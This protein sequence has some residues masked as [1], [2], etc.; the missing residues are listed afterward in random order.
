[1]FEDLDALG[2]GRS[3][4]LE[5]LGKVTLIDVVGAHAD[6]QAMSAHIAVTWDVP[7]ASYGSV[8]LGGPPLD[9][10]F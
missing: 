10:L 7:S 9:F 1:M 3:K 4:V 6:L 5:A 8:V 2:D